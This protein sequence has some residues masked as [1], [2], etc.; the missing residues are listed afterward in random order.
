MPEVKGDSETPNQIPRHVA[1]VMDGNGRWAT[2]RGLPRT[3][4]HRRGAQAARRA[5]EAARD[6]GIEY[7]TLFTFSSE[8]WNRPQDEIDELMDLTRHYLKRETAEMHKSGIRL[9]VIGDRKRLPTDIVA[10]IEQA[11]TVTRDNKLM[12]VCIALSYGGRQEIVLAAQKLARAVS[13]GL[14]EVGE[15]D[16]SLFANQMMTSGIPDPDLMIRTSGESRISNFLL[17]QLAYAELFFSTTLWPDFDKKD[18]EQAIAFYASR[19]RRF[20]GL[21]ATGKP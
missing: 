5:V 20:G 8:N 3:E 7:V 11:E 10:L 21:K 19:E 17:W 6:L 2:A 14:V 15:I 13:Q 12:T 1:I 4:G 16:E 18:L 9:R